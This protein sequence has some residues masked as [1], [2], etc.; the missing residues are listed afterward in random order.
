MASVT[1]VGSVGLGISQGMPLCHPLRYLASSTKK[2]NDTR[3]STNRNII[4]FTSLVAAFEMLLQ[5]KDHIKQ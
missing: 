4:H 3:C 5:R 2:S 1:H